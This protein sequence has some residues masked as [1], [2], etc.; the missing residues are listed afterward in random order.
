MIRNIGSQNSGTIINN[1]TQ[2]NDV[3]N[4]K[5]IEKQALEQQNRV[6]GLKKQI[7]NGE[8]SIDLDATATR[9]AQELKPE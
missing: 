9:M 3:Q 2:K 1:D 8:Y 4:A 5:N 6:D 7:E